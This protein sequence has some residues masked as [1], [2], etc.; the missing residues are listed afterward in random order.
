MNSA[1]HS[2]PVKHRGSIMH[3]PEIT[4]VVDAGAR[5]GMYPSWRDFGGPLSY[6]AF[7]P[8]CS[9]ADRLRAQINPPGF[10][11]IASALGRTAGQGV[12]HSTKHRGCSSLLR[13]DL[14]SD[15]FSSY[16]PDEGE[17]EQTQ[18]VEIMTIDDFAKERQARVEFLKVDTE[19]T[20]L[21][22]LKGGE[23][24]VTENVMGVRVNVNFQPA[25]TGHQLFPEIHC[26]LASKD[27]ILLNFDYFGKGLP[28]FDLFRNP[29]PLTLEVERYGVLTGT[30]AVWI[31]PYERIIS[32]EARN[33]TDLAYTTMKYSYFCYLNHAADVGLDALTQYLSY[34]DHT[35]ASV[36]ESQLY[37]ALRKTWATYLGRWRVYPDMQWE[38]AQRTFKK[39]FELDL[40]PG[41]KYWELIQS[42]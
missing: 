6:F 30:D 18:S 40:E 7:E 27:F 29:D 34:E 31:K 22:V 33:S 28:R 12:L 8:D 26:F 25:Y 13:P 39:A 21:D 16:R 10:E 5:Y 32:Q 42:L 1:P 14:S 23:H 11:V 2:R 37:K 35:F 20:E 17:V 41:N 24:Q 3:D 9:E 36:Q 4:I 38:L 19:G 15:W